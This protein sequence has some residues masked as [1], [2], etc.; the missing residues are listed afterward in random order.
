MP[1]LFFLLDRALQVISALILIRVL[2]SWASV[3]GLNHPL[4]RSLDRA[5]HQLTAPIID[6]IRRVMP[7]TGGFDLSPL[8][9]L[10]LLQVASQLLREVLLNLLP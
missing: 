2:L 6:P 4:V 7:P 9:A 5:V 10:L 1:L 3:F 8:V